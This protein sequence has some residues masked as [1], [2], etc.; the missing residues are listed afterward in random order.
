MFGS[1]SDLRH[2][3]HLSYFQL[4]SKSKTTTTTTTMKFST[5][6]TFF[7]MAVTTLEATRLG[8]PTEVSD[9]SCRT[10]FVGANVRRIFEAADR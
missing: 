8:S 2:F 7:L 3:K 10:W 1:Q 9:S 6:I 4:S 5:T